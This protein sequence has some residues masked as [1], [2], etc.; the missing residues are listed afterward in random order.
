[1]CVFLSLC[2]FFPV[3]FG[4]SY[5]QLVKQFATVSVS[6]VVV[7]VTEVVVLVVLVVVVVVV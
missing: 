4:F 6:V 5:S 1:M 2:V 3:V 7:V